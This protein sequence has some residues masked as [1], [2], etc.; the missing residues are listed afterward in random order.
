MLTSTAIV[1]QISLR[2]EV[3]S[4]KLGDRRR[5]ERYAKLV[6]RLAVEPAASIPT[7]MGDEAACEAYYRF[8]RNN[9]IEHFKLI[10][11]HID[12]TVLRCKDLDVVLVAH[13]TTEFA[14][15]IHEQPARKG[16]PR[17]S[18]KRQGFKWHAS[19]ALSADGLRTPLGLLNS[20]PFVHDNDDLQACDR[21]FWDNI[22][23]IFNNEQERWFE[24]V[25]NVEARLEGVTKVVHIMDREA[26]DYRGLVGMEGC[27]Y[28]FVVRMVKGRNVSTGPLRKDKDKLANA[29]EKTPWQTQTREVKL[30]ARSNSSKSYPARR[31]RVATFKIRAATVE[32]RRPNNVEAA[33]SPNSETFN[34]VEVQEVNAPQGQ[35]AVRWLLV[36]NE[37]ID[38]DDGAWQIV[39]WYRARWV[40]EEYFKAIKTGCSYQKLQHKRV[41]TLLAALAAKAV[42]GWNLLVL[43]HLGR[44]NPT[45]DAL[46]VVNEVQLQVL[47]GLK[48][49]LI[50]AQPTAGDVMAAVAALGG[51]FKRNGFA[52]WLILGRGWRKLLEV[53]RGFRLAM[54]TLHEM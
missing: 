34:V 46:R 18:S 30:S 23:G 37:A 32:L 25:A 28:G 48:P 41:E 35:E 5:S 24:A 49:K 51:H 52:G 9:A 10:D 7:A 40:V 11:P 6:E 13:D 42:V 4:A 19:L 31:A 36:T 45:E 12:N 2:D 38:G 29:L 14:F 33:G 26:D 17:L 47:R 50:G 27:G 21:P 53:E 8:M 3:L 44:H 43:R 22:G 16:L 39:D 15:D 1:S 20:M 54:A